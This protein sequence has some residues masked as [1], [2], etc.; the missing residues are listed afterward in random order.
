M[1]SSKILNKIQSLVLDLSP[2]NPPIVN[3]EEKVDY[4]SFN[5]LVHREDNLLTI[6][7]HPLFKN[8]DDDELMLKIYDLIMSKGKDQTLS[9]HILPIMQELHSTHNF[10]KSFSK[11]I[12]KMV[13]FNKMFQSLKDAVANQPPQHNSSVIIN[14]MIYSSVQT[15]SESKQQNMYKF[16]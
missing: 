1:A 8:H 2:F 3:N 6:F 11:N 13:N 15:P 9:R 10:K 16:R 14:Y 5:Q 4:S 12:T 7:K